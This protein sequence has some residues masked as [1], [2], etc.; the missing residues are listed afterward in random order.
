M[1]TTHRI[2]AVAHAGSLAAAALVVLLASPAFAQSTAPAIAAPALDSVYQWPVYETNDHVTIGTR[3][4]RRT[5]PSE[6][7]ARSPNPAV[8]HWPAYDG[9]GRLTNDIW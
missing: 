5:M 4:A 8:F 2:P 9:S 3:V 6:A 7:F 1:K